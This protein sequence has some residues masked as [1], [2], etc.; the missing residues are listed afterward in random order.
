[1]S[2]RSL[3]RSDASDAIVDILLTVICDQGAKIKEFG[4]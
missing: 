4:I 1:E 2:I 3:K